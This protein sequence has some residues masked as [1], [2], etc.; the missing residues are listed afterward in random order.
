[1]KKLFFILLF[2]NVALFG[3]IRL[4]ETQSP[5][6][7]RSRETNANQVKVVTGQLN[8]RNTVASEV[9]TASVPATSAASAPTPSS[10]AM[11]SSISTAS[12][13]CMKLVGVTAE[14]L[15]QARSKIKAAKL[16]SEESSVGENRFWVYIPPFA[17]IDAAKKKAE[18]LAKLGI[19]DFY[20]INNGSKWQNAVSLGVYS[21]REAGE[22]RLAQLKEKGVR[23]AQLRDKDDTPKAVTLTFRQIGTAD[24]EKLE[25]IS[26]QLRGAE[27]QEISCR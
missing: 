7:W 23:S 13:I 3:L 21:T 27:L 22:K 2:I 5:I 11:S 8:S 19:D 16:A 4:H 14:L 6:D 1:M 10:L 9:A 24:R 15:P 25:K 12:A 20:A 17:S 26:S 18:E